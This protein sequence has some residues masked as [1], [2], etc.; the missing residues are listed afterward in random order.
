MDR[1]FKD[2]VT[3]ERTKLLK[4][5]FQDLEELAAESEVRDFCCCCY[6]PCSCSCC[7]C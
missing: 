1:F 3:A 5:G 4:Q 2:L 7:S 6:Y